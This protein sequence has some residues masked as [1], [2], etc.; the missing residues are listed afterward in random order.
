MK[1]IINFSLRVTFIKGFVDTKIYK[2]QKPE[3]WRHVC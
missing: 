3:R 2:P 1:K